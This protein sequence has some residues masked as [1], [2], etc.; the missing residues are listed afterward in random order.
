MFRKRGDWD[1]HSCGKHNFASRRNCFGCGRVKT[2]ARPE[3]SQR[4]A[5]DWDCPNCNELIFAS[6]ASCRRCGAKNPNSALNMGMAERSGDWECPQ[7]KHHVFGWRDRCNLCQTNK[8]D[9]IAE[10]N[11]AQNRPPPRDLP[12]D[13]I[14]TDCNTHN[15]R[16]RVVCRKCRKVS[17][18]VDTTQD[19]NL[20][21]PA[22]VEEAEHDSNCVVC[23]TEPARMAITVCGHM[24]LCDQ[25]CQLIDKC[26]LCRKNYTP[27]QVIKIFTV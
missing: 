26:P 22:P 14:C 1:C 20:P 21:M 6:K 16:G 19:Q 3:Q 5:G 24:A 9:G 25:C 7:C 8:P 18:V 12:G 27:Q 11:A 15:F 4:R 2:G 13:W 10:R 17:P 23:L